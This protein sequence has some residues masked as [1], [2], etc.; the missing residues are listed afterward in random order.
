MADT[1]PGLDTPQ[2]VQVGQDVRGVVSDGL[3]VL[4][5]GGGDP[6]VDGQPVDVVL[7]V[8][9]GLGLAVEEAGVD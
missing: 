6:V 9:E 3:E 8:E 4:L 1:G 2:G 5:S 7:V